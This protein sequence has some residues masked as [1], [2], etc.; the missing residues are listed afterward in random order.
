MDASANGDHEYL[1]FFFFEAV[2]GVNLIHIRE[3]FIGKRSP[4]QAEKVEK[5]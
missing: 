5:K 4:G 3:L 1:F 2:L